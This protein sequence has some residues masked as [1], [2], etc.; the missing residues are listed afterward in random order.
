MKWLL[1]KTS[2]LFSFIEEQPLSYGLFS[3]A[4]L[5]LLFTRILLENWLFGFK[6]RSALLFWYEFSHLSLFF[7][8]AFLI[9]FLV[10]RSIVPEAMRRANIL[11]FGFLVIL[12]PPVIDFWISGGSGFWSFYSF[13]SLS[14]LAHRYITFFG[15]RPDFGIT[16]GVRAEVAIV[17][18]FLTLFVFIK[19]RKPFQSFLFAL[20]SYTIL[21]F[22]GTFPSWVSYA[23]LGHSSGITTL[24]DMDIAGLFL[25]PTHLFFQ[26]SPGLQLAL[27]LKMGLVYASLLP[28][29][30]GIVLFFSWN[31]LFRAL[32]R[33][34]RWPQVIYH[35]GLF[36]IGIGL[37]FLI[38]G[39][40]LSFSFF[41]TL[42]VWAS[43]IA[44][45]AAWMASVVV[46]DLFDEAIDRETNPDRPLPT[47]NIPRKQYQAIGITLFIFSLFLSAIPNFLGA[48]F[49]LA[50]QAIA[51]IYSAPPFR[52]KRFPII[53]TAASAV[54]SFLILLVGFSLSAKPESLSAIP[55]SMIILLLLAYTLALPLKDFKDI[56]GDKKAGVWTIPVLFG[57]F[58]AKLII[59]SG[60]FLSFLASVFFLKSTTLFIPSLLA[61]SASFWMILSMRERRGAIHARNIFWWIL[62]LTAFYGLYVATV[63][64]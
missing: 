23:V 33:N 34:A 61:G 7:L 50:Y 19:T 18:L 13:D 31:H 24:R 28:F 37:G 2:A 39:A 62:G 52:L 51:W 5:S 35:G 44:T 15:D 40:K 63:A 57:V 20:C 49:L 45:I 64:L 60:I 10:L 6:T 43:L 36:A 4:F 25:S 17:T 3:T 32:F 42:A 16:Y 55:V 56:E 38:S 29:L 59:G 58:R 53:A 46:N 30:I 21:F 22:L 41:E 9:F 14:G 11:L 12:L 48:F 8:S 1:S 27:S 54:A 26:S 47:G